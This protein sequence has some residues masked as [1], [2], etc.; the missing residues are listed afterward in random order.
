[1]PVNQCQ[2]THL[3]YDAPVDQ[4]FY[5]YGFSTSIANQGVLKTAFISFSQL[6]IPNTKKIEHI[7]A[8]GNFEQIFICGPLLRLANPASC[9]H[10]YV[11]IGIHIKRWDVITR[12]CPNFKGCLVTVVGIG[13]RVSTNIP[14]KIFD[15]FTELWPN[16]SRSLL[17]K[18]TLW[19]GDAGSRY[20]RFKIGVMKYNIDPLLINT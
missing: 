12:P 16:L 9:L 11:W 19:D 8:F 2:Q 15:M 6:L 13:A 3:I 10:G 17:V 7:S 5:W 20:S 18:G 14:H 1:M 4:H